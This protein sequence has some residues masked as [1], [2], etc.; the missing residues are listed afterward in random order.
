MSKE[1]S[2]F[3]D[4]KSKHTFKILI[5][6][7]PHREVIFVSKAYGG[8]TSDSQIVNESGTLDL[9][10]PKDLVLGDKGFPQTADNPSEAGGSLVVPPNKTV[11][12]QFTTLQ[13][14]Y[15]HQTSTLKILVECQV[16]R[17]KT[18]AALKF[19][20]HNLYKDVDKIVWCA[21]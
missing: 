9:T 2:T 1:V 7:A 21:L 11:S 5:G 20:T 6:I 3:S 12:F 10:E 16:S 18:F 15:G 14:L 17:I 4:Y 8:R 13:N 19:V